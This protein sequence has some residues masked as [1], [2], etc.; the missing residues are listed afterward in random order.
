MSAAAGHAPAGAVHVVIMSK[1]PE[2]RD[3]YCKQ[4]ASQIE[5]VILGA[6]AEGMTPA[7]YA[8]EDGTF[9]EQTGEFACLSCYIDL[10]MPAS[11]AGWKAG[12]P[13][14]QSAYA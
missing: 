8:Q 12:Q 5:D 7:E 1:S 9:N 2:P 3:P 6:R 4:S 13:V 14:P 11:A 10:G